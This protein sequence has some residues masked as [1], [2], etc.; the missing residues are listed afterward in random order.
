MES[1]L[2]PVELSIN[3]NIEKPIGT[4]QILQTLLN[5]FGEECYILVDRLSGEDKTNPTHLN[6]IEKT[7]LLTLYEN[8]KQYRWE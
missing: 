4:Y 7:A 3:S 2:I 8:I 6:E 1:F 5:A